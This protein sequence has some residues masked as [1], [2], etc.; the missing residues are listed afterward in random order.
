MRPLR[1]PKDGARITVAAEIL[2]LSTGTTGGMQEVLM[3][4]ADFL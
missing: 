2:E 3:N 1:M 4:A